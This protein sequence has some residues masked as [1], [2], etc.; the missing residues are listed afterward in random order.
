MFDYAA[1]D[2]ARQPRGCDRTE[3]AIAEIGESIEH[4]RDEHVAGYTADG[5]E[6][7]MHVILKRSTRMRP[8]RE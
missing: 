7:D 2:P 5:V 1:H 4:G 3:H 6:M 8:L